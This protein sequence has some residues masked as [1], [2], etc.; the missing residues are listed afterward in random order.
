MTNLQLSLELSEIPCYMHEGIIL[1]IENHIP[2]GDFLSAILCNDLYEACGR[3]DDTNCHLLYEY[4]SWFY[5][6]VSDNCW[7]S[8]ERYNQWIKKEK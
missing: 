1:Y 5:G 6:N 7:G 2:P 4:V 8:P 3:A